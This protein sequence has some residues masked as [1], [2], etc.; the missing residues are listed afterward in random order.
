MRGRTSWWLIVLAVIAVVLLCLGFAW[1]H[2]QQVR[3][4]HNLGGQ[5]VTDH[6]TTRVYDTKTGKWKTRTDTEHECIV[7]GREVFEW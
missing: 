4:C 1:L 7:G 6:D 3:R 2:N 5:V